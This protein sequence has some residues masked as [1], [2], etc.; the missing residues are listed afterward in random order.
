MFS[1]SVDVIELGDPCRASGV[2]DFSAELNSAISVYPNPTSG[3]VLVSLNAAR[4]L[5]G[6]I[7]VIDVNGKLMQEQAIDVNGQADF[8]LSLERLPAG[9]Y[10]IL[11]R[12]NEG[13]AT[14][15]FQKNNGFFLFSRLNK[16][17]STDNEK[18]IQPSCIGRSI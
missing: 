7:Q 3:L 10:T 8:S 1:L 15:L 17:Q 5:T 12:T 16:K 6:S 14:K 2:K 11:L 13:F 4:R 9:L 18:I